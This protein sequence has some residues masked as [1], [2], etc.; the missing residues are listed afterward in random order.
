[1]RDERRGV[2]PGRVDQLAH[3]SFERL[4]GQYAPPPVKLAC[5]LLHDEI[6]GCFEEELGPGTAAHDIGQK[7]IRLFGK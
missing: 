6:R 1:M 3:A 7:L 4:L 2:E 5:V